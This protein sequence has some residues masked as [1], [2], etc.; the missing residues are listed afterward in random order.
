M[1]LP[2]GTCSITHAGTPVLSGD[3]TLVLSARVGRTCLRIRDDSWLKSNDRIRI[4]AKEQRKNSVQ[5]LT[6]RKPFLGW[7][8]SKSL[9]YLD[10]VTLEHLEDFRAT[11]PGNAATRRYRPYFAAS[12]AIAR[13]IPTGSM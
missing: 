2:G 4:V 5:I 7:T 1:I 12:S 8:K 13:C 6:I 10:E 3:N 11:L 9:V